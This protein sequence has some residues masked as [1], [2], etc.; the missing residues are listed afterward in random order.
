MR[1]KAL[2]QETAA[3]LLHGTTMEELCRCI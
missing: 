2:L 1:S 3:L